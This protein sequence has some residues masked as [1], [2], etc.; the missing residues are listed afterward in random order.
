[1]SLAMAAMEAERS[2][3]QQWV[4]HSTQ[5][6]TCSG[7]GRAALTPLPLAAGRQ[8]ALPSYNL[9]PVLHSGGGMLLSHA[10]HAHSSVWPAAL[11]DNTFS[12]RG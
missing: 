5:P 8:D 6:R 11:P 10:S 1:M 2:Y 7:I 4:L 12:I 9:C 3:L